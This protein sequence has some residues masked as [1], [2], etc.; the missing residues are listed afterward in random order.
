MKKPMDPKDMPTWQRFTE[1][2]FRTEDADPGYIALARCRL[3]EDVRM[4]LIVGWVTFYNL[5]LACNAAKLTGPKF[6]AYLR[7]VY[8]T[9]KR[10]SERRHFRGKAGLKALA[11]WER[12][13]PRPEM[14]VERIL[15]ASPDYTSVRN[16]VRPI[17]QMGDYFVWKFCDLYDVMTKRHVDVTG[18]ESYAPKT[19]QQGA[20]L[21]FPDNTIAEAFSKIVAYARK[22]GLTAPPHHNR[23]FDANEAETVCCVYK[24]MAG[25]GYTWGLRTAKARNRIL[26]A[27]PSPIRTSLHSGLMAQSVWTDQELEVIFNNAH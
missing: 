26:S 1:K 15:K 17:T 20:K 7:S 13:Y 23:P 11:D 25:G 21:I 9:A 8:P 22:I 27:D 2:L 18:C 14:M 12:D 6:W 24:Q 16:R 19:P 3:P 5:G 4:R 10:A